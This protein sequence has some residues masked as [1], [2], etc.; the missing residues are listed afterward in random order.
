VRARA[1]T[2]TRK[3]GADQVDTATL[4]V[5]FV[6]DNEEALDRAAL[7]PPSVTATALRLSEQTTFTAQS[8][9]VWSPDLATLRERCNELETAMKAPGRA[10]ADVATVARANRR[11]IESVLA[12]AQTELGR[13]GIF[14]E[15]RSSGLHNQLATLSD[16]IARSEDERTSSRPPTRPYVVDVEHTSILEIAVRERQDAAELLDLNAAR[17]ADPFDLSRGDVIKIFVTAA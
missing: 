8:L 9:G 13:L 11:A 6:Q 10:S 12:T 14:G 7:N 17:V 3:E 1:E 4:T 15:P 16:R 5:T 2:Y